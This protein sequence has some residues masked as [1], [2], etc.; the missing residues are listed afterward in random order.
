MQICHR[1]GVSVAL[2]LFAALAS[3]ATAEAH[4]SI[5]WYT[6]YE[7]AVKAT[8][9]QNRPMLLFI[10]MDGCHFCTLMKQKTYGDQAVVT[11]VGRKFVAA[12][13]NA[14]KNIPL[15]RRFGVTVFPTTLIIAPNSDVLDV[16]RGYITSQD[17]RVRLATI[18]SASY[19]TADRDDQR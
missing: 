2:V 15:A 7:D 16:I 6:D 1:L 9:A 8:R 14:R 10:T 12:R 4:R 17:L 19:R 18:P 13:L 11:D 5:A 3:T